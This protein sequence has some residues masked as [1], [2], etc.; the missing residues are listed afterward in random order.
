MGRAASQQ[1]LRLP[2]LASVAV[3]VVMV[4][5]P[6]ASATAAGTGRARQGSQPVSVVIDSISPQ[7]ARPGAT[8]TV[9]GTVANHSGDAVQGVSVQLRSSGV[10]L[11]N[12]DQL[13]A[14]A[15]GGYAADQP[16]GIPTMIGG[17]VRPGG[18]ARWQVSL[19]V[20]DLGL[21]SFGVYPLAAEADDVTGTL[22][23][24]DRSFL[25]FWPGGSPSLL[26]RPLK[27]AWIWPLIDQPRQGACPSSLTDSGL[28]A[29]VAADGRLGG[30]LRAGASYAGQARL[31]WAIDPALLSDVQTMTRPYQVGGG[32][33]CVGATGRP[34]SR[35]AAAWLG[36]LRSA[37]AGGQAFV[38]PYADVDV[39]AL[40]HAGFDQ[41]L[42]YA[43]SEGR[44][45][46]NG[47]LGRSF[48][49]SASPD[50]VAWPAGGLADS[51]VLGNLAV[52]GVGTVVLDAAAMPP[53][54]PALTYT[55]SAVTSTPSG[56]GPTLNVLLADDT[57]TQ[58]LGA[59]PAA[60]A[61]PGAAF[62][63][64]Q[65][66]LAE[67]AM[68]DAEAP[69][70]AR[71]IVITPPRRW[72]PAP[73]LASALLSETVAAPWLQPASLTGLVNSGGSGQVARQPPPASQLS[74]SELGRAY[75][76]GLQKLDKSLKLYSSILLQP[77]QR[78]LTSLQ[79]AVTAA[80]SSGWRGGGTAGRRGMELINRAA[81]YIAAQERK[82]RIISSAQVT[83]GGSSGTVPV[84]IANGLGQRVE[85]RLQASVPGTGRLTIGSYQAE[86]VVGPRQTVT[87]RLPIH[88]S[89]IGA[90]T[91][92]LRLLSKDG[93]PLPGQPVPLNVQA[94]R[95]GTMALLIIGAA[96]GVFVLASAVR[97]VRRG[98]RDG[99]PGADAGQERADEA[100]PGEGADN[101][102]HDDDRTDENY[103]PEAPDEY[104][105]AQG[106]ADSPRPG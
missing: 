100:G 71:S 65:R 27:A 50:A 16:E 86:V 54:S 101:V 104:A 58:I 81:G 76:G 61:A 29:S 78:Y 102:E 90:T 48:T 5:A 79:S 55:P 51:G 28:A 84:S 4:I 64:E 70:L 30:L 38:T 1:V 20:N 11:S 66:F 83:L 24:T 15:A 8:V 73:G 45:I 9:T 53:A 7:I 63:V 106:R 52:N 12:R 72:D 69:N 10:Q 33:N 35:T 3:A 95:L 41:D 42:R 80:E 60:S 34:A 6:A 40:T 22:L 39:A 74:G 96:L 82:V 18:T 44:S 85:L 97:A 98:F 23:D 43:V 88:A 87:V 32:V 92:H 46:A 14:Y 103:P 91:M 67:T 47:V 49:A 62:A 26:P 89:A 13:A 19:P 57:L 68:I 99:R 93:I 77:T 31:T 94:T 17:T 56:V 21:T 2:L 75:L 37:T 36:S 25:P 105:D 59:A